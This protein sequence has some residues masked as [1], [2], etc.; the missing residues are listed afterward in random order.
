MLNR[1]RQSIKE[2]K[3]LSENDFLEGCA[4]TSARAKG[5]R[6]N[7]PPYQALRGEARTAR[8]DGSSLVPR[9]RAGPGGLNPGPSP[10]PM[11]IGSRRS[12][13]SADRLPNISR[14]RSRPCPSPSTPRCTRL[15]EIEPAA[16]LEFL[17]IAVPDP[18]PGRGD[19]REPLDGHRRIR[20][21]DPPGR[22]GPVDPPHRIPLRPR[23]SPI[24]ATCIGIMRWRPTS[25]RHR[26]GRC[27]SCSARRPTARS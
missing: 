14:P 13:I 26:S 6:Q 7:R 15:Y 19:R 20:Q 5:R 24:L 9:P 27:C 12:S 16:W 21:A 3:G 2:G 1:S 10:M 17:G 18:E 4:E 25:T 8:T 11:M 22:A 23:S